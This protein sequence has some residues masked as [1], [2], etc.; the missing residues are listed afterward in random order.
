M[1]SFLYA[2]PSHLGGINSG[3]RQKGLASVST[4]RRESAA[5]HMLMHTK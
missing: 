1:Y 2:A 4:A 3:E 5:Q